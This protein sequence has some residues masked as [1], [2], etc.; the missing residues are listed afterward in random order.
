[1]C[2]GMATRDC[3]FSFVIFC[4]DE[5]GDCRHVQIIVPFT[6]NREAKISY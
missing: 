4:G 1:M 3:V 6:T 2:K 5:L